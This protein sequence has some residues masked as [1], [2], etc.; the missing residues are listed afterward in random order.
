[1]STK[2]VKYSQMHKFYFICFKK[3][4]IFALMKKYYYLLCALISFGF[5]VQTSAQKIYC[6]TNDSAFEIHA[7]QTLSETNPGWDIVG[8]FKTKDRTTR[9][10]MGKNSTVSLS[11]VQPKF[12]ILLAPHE[13]ITQYVLVKLKTFKQY[14]TIPQKT[15]Q[16]KR[17][18]ALSPENF[19]IS[20]GE[21]EQFVCQYRHTLPP[22]EYMLMNKMQVTDAH[23]PN[24]E[25][26][27]FRV[28]K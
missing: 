6:I 27:P 24:Y 1:M 7:E 2:D 5:A 10:L 8:M 28:V 17:Y 22:G 21:N 4:I 16:K 15:F 9:Y 26:F 25:V 23:H 13:L 12:G 18:I 3:R 11:S 20:I 14:R 19:H